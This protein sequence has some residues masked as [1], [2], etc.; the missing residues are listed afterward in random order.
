[1]PCSCQSQMAGCTKNRRA[2]LKQ[3]VAS[4]ISFVYEYSHQSPRRRRFEAPGSRPWLEHLGYAQRV[5]SCPA[6]Q[7]PAPIT[8][9][10]T[11]SARRDRTSQQAVWLCTISLSSALD[12]LWL[13]NSRDASTTNGLSSTTSLDRSIFSTPGTG[14]TDGGLTSGCAVCAHADERISIPAASKVA[15]NK[16]GDVGIRFIEVMR[17]G[18]CKGLEIFAARRTKDIPPIA[19]C[20]FP[21][22]TA[23]ISAGK[24][25][26]TDAAVAANASVS[27]GLKRVL[28]TEFF[29][30]P[31]RYLM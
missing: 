14:V 9:A 18:W 15:A 16:P 25:H 7:A 11:I 27:T 21:R 28:T 26:R 22:E 24:N 31:S 4:S 20:W 6:G 1:M 19:A 12:G 2:P 17:R 8:K 3:P 13:K 23:G 10:V 29:S 30:G 5:A